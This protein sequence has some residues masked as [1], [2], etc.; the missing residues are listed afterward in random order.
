MCSQLVDLSLTHRSHQSFSV[1]ESNTLSPLEIPTRTGIVNTGSGPANQIQT[2]K[3]KLLQGMYL[4]FLL[5]AMPTTLPILHIDVL[6]EKHTIDDVGV[7]DIVGVI[8]LALTHSSVHP[9]FLQVLNEIHAVL[10]RSLELYISITNHIDRLLSKESQTSPGTS[11]KRCSAVE[12]SLS[13][14]CSMNCRAW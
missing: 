7:Q 1:S 8:V 3:S 13:S 2:Q 14:K 6:A 9:T 5:Y 12:M 11:K 10:R 4:L